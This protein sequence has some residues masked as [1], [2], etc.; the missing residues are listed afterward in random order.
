MKKILGLFVIL[1]LSQNTFS[2]EGKKKIYL[3][4]D[5]LNQPKINKQIEIKWTSPFHY[6]FI[7]NV[8]YK[9]PYYNYVEFSTW[10]DKKKP[11]P[12]VELSKP[13]YPFVKL[14]ELLNKVKESPL[15]FSD[16]FDLY[17]TEVLP[18]KR[19]QT[20]KVILMPQQAPTQSGAS[21]KNKLK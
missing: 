13:K 3:L 19:F 5:T 10:I 8:P 2:Q 4:V 16:E 17:I 21:L 12:P 20:F 9:A 6:A 1:F 7:F 18:K 14:T 11:K 15:Y